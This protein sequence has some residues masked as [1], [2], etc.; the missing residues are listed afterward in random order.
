VVAPEA[1]DAFVGAARGAGD[2][3]REDLLLLGLQVLLDLRRDGDEVRREPDGPVGPRGVRAVDLPG[4]IQDLRQLLAQPRVIAVHDVAYE[5]RRRTRVPADALVVGRRPLVV[6]DLG[7]DRVGIDAARRRRPRQ[8]L[9]AAAAEVDPVPLQDPRGPG[10]ASD[11]VAERIVP[12]VVE[13]RVL[14][15]G[16]TDR[17]LPGAAGEHEERGEGEGR[18]TRAVVAG[19]RGLRTEDRIARYASRGGGFN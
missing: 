4:Q 1:G 2:D 13:R 10:L 17:V 18:G 14:P 9:A 6:A 12:D 3:A 5:L 19:H 15:R 8:R 16:R 7:E 11:Q